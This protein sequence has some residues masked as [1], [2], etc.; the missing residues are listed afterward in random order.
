MAVMDIACL[1]TDSKYQLKNLLYVIILQSEIEAEST[2]RL[3][4]PIILDNIFP[5]T[6]KASSDSKS[7]TADVSNKFSYLILQLIEVV[8]GVIILII[9]KF[10]IYLRFR[11]QQV[12]TLDT[13]KIYGFCHCCPRHEMK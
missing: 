6:S 3:T 5:P 7:T 10:Q 11:F 13:T 2:Q 9:I 12:I 1:F 8:G 4:R